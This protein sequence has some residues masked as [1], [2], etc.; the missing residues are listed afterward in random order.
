MKAGAG[1]GAAAAAS[2]AL[3]LE[4]TKP[5]ESAHS[6]WSAGTRPSWRSCTALVSGSLFRSPQKN[7]AGLTLP[8]A[9]VPP[10]PPS[11][12]TSFKSAS[13]CLRSA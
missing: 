11:A 6:K 4:N 5:A 2:G 3:S 10:P 13:T 8:A 7:T 1:F 12:S 9:A